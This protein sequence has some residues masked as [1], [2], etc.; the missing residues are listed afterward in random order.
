MARQKGYK[1]S[2]E[3]KRKYT[4]EIKGINDNEFNYRNVGSFET[5]KQALECYNFY[6]SG[7]EKRIKLIT[8]ETK[9]KIMRKKRY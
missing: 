3:T 1:H 9:E 7:C 6:K 2:E 4:V 8:V 5:L